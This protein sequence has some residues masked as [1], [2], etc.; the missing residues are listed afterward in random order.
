MLSVYS[1]YLG[2]IDNFQKHATFVRLE[3]Y[4]GSDEKATLF[5]TTLA[6]EACIRS[7]R[8]WT[9]DADAEEMAT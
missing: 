3:E 1:R 7:L 2:E 4:R 8:S 5:T 9:N 6:L